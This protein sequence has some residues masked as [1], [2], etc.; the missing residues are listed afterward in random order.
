MR[1]DFPAVVTAAYIAANAIN[2]HMLSSPFV[3]LLND[4]TRQPQE[5]AGPQASFHEK[6]FPPDPALS[7]SFVV[8]T[9][10]G[11]TGRREAEICSS[12]PAVPTDPSTWHGVSTLSWTVVFLLSSWLIF[13][14]TCSHPKGLQCDLRPLPV[15]FFLAEQVCRCTIQYPQILPLVALKTY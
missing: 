14:S 1:L 10:Q 15:L 6:C 9:G 13:F 8:G 11:K 4:S 12:L 7:S 3:T 2:A 5:T